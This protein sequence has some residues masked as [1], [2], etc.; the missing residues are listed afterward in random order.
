MFVKKEL[1]IDTK[2]PVN[3]KN[4]DFSTGRTGVLIAIIARK[5]YYKK[6]I[7]KQNY[8]LDIIFFLILSG[9]GRKLRHLVFY[10]FYLVT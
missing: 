1:I 6:F 9:N 3:K 8:S 5:V 7:S 10:N 2:K 4:Y